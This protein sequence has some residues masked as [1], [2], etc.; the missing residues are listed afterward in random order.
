MELLG[1]VPSGV[2]WARAQ[3]REEA[4]APPRAKQQDAQNLQPQR[5]QHRVIPDIAPPKESVV[6]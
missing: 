2:S 6:E 5:L 3:L 4:I 1:R